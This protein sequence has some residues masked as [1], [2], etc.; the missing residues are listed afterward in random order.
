M[1][2]LWQHAA[3]VNNVN[4]V[5]LSVNDHELSISRAASFLYP[6][7]IVFWRRNCC[8]CCL[9]A[10]SVGAAVQVESF[11]AGLR[12]AESVIIACN[13]QDPMTFGPPLACEFPI[14]RLEFSDFAAGCPIGSEFVGRSPKQRIRP[15]R[16]LSDM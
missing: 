16:V 10:E 13:R 5:K 11:V 1:Q 6:S 2:W 3:D 15:G 7:W 4:N 8:C 14:C 9:T 12:L